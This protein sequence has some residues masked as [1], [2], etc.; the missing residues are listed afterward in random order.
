MLGRPEFDEGDPLHRDH[1]IFSDAGD[2]LENSGDEII[3]IAEIVEG[4][5][6]MGPRKRS[7]RGLGA[8][9]QF[10]GLRRRALAEPDRRFEEEPQMLGRLAQDFRQPAGTE[11]LAPCLLAADELTKER[12]ADRELRVFLADRVEL[13]IGAFEIAGEAQQLAEK[14]A[15]VGVARI[16]PHLLVHGG[17]GLGEATRFEML[18][19]GRHGSLGCDG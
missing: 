13:Q 7:P 2:D 14:A 16:G 6:V 17:D 15:P 5:A 11:E 18:P 8:R 10:R 9:Q 1:V 3:E 4:L 19:D 12:D